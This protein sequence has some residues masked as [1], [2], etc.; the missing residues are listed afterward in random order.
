VRRKHRRSEPTAPQPD[1]PKP[2]KPSWEKF[3]DTEER[4]SREDLAAG[5]DVFT[6]SVLEPVPLPRWLRG[7]RRPPRDKLS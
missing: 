6:D 2:A 5:H 7:R 4:P 3:L 1:P